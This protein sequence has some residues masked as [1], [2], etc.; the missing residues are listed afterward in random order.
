MLRTVVLHTHR[1]RK[2]N[3]LKEGGTGE[4]SQTVGNSI[5]SKV[6]GNNNLK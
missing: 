4:R 2:G 1:R 3:K 5:K 6:G